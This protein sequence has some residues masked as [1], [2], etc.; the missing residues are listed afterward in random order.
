MLVKSAHA[1]PNASGEYTPSSQ[2][3]P[4]KVLQQ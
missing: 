4:H 3:D 1:L 2:F